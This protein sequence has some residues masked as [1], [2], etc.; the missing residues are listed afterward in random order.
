[1]KIVTLKEFLKLPPLT[2][3]CT[4][5]P[6]IFGPL[7]TKGD[8]LNELDFIEASIT[9]EVNSNTFGE[10]IDLLDDAVEKGTT[11]K[12]EQYCYGRNGMLD[13]DG[14]FAIYEPEDLI[15]IINVLMSGGMAIDLHR[16]GVKNAV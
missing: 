5:E 9:D 16:K 15:G 14:L 3:F 11:I 2:I 1:M 4:Y 6:C 7:M 8:T 12:L 13:R 10:T